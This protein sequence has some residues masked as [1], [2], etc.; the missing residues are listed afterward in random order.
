[1]VVAVATDQPGEALTW[2]ATA[3]LAVELAEAGLETAV[4]R[5]LGAGTATVHRRSARRGWGGHKQRQ[6][7]AAEPGAQHVCTWA[8]CHLRPKRASKRPIRAPSRGMVYINKLCGPE[9]G[10]D[11]HGFS[12]GWYLKK[13]SPSR[14]SGQ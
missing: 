13:D 2:V 8:G 6:H 1:M 4:C 7:P 9:K 3:K 5:S 11:R 10:G 14:Q 12:R